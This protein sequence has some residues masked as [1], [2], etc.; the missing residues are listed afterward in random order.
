M[1]ITAERKQEL[2]VEYRTKDGDTG[3]P[4]V[5]AGVAAGQILAIQ[6]ATQPPA[7]ILPPSNP[8]RPGKPHRRG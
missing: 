8:H 2:I 6:R 4:D 7:A 3:S 5:P 1:S